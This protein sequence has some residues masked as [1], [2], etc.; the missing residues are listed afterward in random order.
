MAG[1]PVPSDP[2]EF[3]RV[4]ALPGVARPGESWQGRLPR[5]LPPGTGR[6]P[7]PGSCPC[8]APGAVFAGAHLLCLTPSTLAAVSPR[9]SC[10]S[11]PSPPGPPRRP[12]KLNRV[13]TSR[14]VVEFPTWRLGR[15]EVALVSTSPSR[16]QSAGTFLP[17]RLSSDV[18]GRWVSRTDPG[19]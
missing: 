9:D 14:R 5:G 13:E 3:S 6:T 19:H 18:L 16:K 8:F 4:C 10:T 1:G 15:A 2:A 12:L 7:V 17:P 11:V